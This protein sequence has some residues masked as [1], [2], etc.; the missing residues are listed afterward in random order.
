VAVGVGGGEEV[1]G[2]G[3]RRTLKA[4]GVPCLLDA[5]IRV[6]RSA[7]PGGDA[8]GGGP[9]LTR[10]DIERL[11]AVFGE[12]RLDA[13]RGSVAF[14]EAFELRTL[15]AVASSAP[16]MLWSTGA[17]WRGGAA[18]HGTADGPRQRPGRT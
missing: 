17:E 15:R 13:P 10:W 2:G 3:R 11:K 1:G 12:C 9:R 14:N 4:A 8:I 6:A 18:R 5:R 7:H 16:T